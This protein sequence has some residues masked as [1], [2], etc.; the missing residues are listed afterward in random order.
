[1]PDQPKYEDIAKFADAFTDKAKG[2][3]GITLRGKPGWG[4]NIAY[5]GTLTNTFGGTWFD[6]A[7]LRF[8]KNFAGLLYFFMEERAACCGR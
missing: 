6:R 8:V 3:Y 1:M 5:L 2:L 7:H 4:E